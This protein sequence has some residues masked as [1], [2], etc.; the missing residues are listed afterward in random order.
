M[1]NIIN[2]SFEEYHMILVKHKL[3]LLEAVVR[4]VGEKTDELSLQEKNC[5]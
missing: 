4:K 1:A 2:N 5:L 3:K